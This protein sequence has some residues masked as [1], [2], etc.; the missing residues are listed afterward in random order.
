MVCDLKK[1]S[2]TLFLLAFYLLLFTFASTYVNASAV[3]AKTASS[4][5][6]V[7]VDQVSHTIKIQEGALV[8][9]NDTLRL[10][11]KAGESTVSLQ[12]FSLGFPFQYGFDLDYCFAYEASDPDTWLDVEFDT[13][14]GRLG[15][16]GVNVVFPEPGVNIGEG[17]SYNLAVIFVF[18]NLY[19]LK[20]QP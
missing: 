16:Y 5:A 4:S 20:L 2:I 3:N 13:G 7:Q 10:S 19:P 11:P 15:F 8:I 12:N 6:D 18:S 17:E 14:L 9:I 1:A